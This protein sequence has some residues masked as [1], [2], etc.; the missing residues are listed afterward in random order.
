MKKIEILI[1]VDAAGA[2]ASNDL[3][4]NVYLVDTNKY[5]IA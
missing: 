2:L 4:N 5:S 1:I 3:S